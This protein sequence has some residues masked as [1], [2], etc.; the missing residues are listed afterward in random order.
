MGLA[1]GTHGSNIPQVRK[2]PGV[3]SI[4]LDEDS[5]TFRMYGDSTDAVK[6]ARDFLEFVKDFIQVPRNLTG[7][8]IGKNGKVLQ[9]T[10]DK[11]GVV[12]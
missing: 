3:I 7:K 11:S 2:F 4:E 12:W 9:A 5:E 10:V 8:V 1:I 6:K